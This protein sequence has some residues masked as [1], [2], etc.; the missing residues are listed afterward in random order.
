MPSIQVAKYLTFKKGGVSSREESDRARRANRRRLLRHWTWCG[1]VCSTWL[2]RYIRWGGTEGAA[3]GGKPGLDGDGSRPE[4]DGADESEDRRDR[5]AGRRRGRDGLNGALFR[6]HLVVYQ[7]CFGG[8]GLCLVARRGGILDYR[9]APRG[10]QAR[11][12][13]PR[14]V[15]L[16]PG[17]VEIGAPGGGRVPLDVGAV[18]LGVGGRVLLGDIDAGRRRARRREV[19]AEKVRA[20]A[21]TAGVVRGCLLYTSPS[22]RDQRGSRMPS[23][24]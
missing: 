19:A 4:R 18:T 22:P 20:V 3:P 15:E 12:A 24:A 10:V 6:V 1:V 13:R 14:R 17:A 21:S 2:A 5:G 16:R 23:S 7:I 11:V 8:R 9:C